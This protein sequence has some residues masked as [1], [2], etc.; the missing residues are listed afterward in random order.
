MVTKLTDLME[1]KQS[2]QTELVQIQSML[3]LIDD[4]IAEE[5]LDALDWD[6]ETREDG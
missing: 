4:C 3:Y 6:D 1:Q 5:V 2:L